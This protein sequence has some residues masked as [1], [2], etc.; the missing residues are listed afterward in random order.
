[1]KTS[2]SPT[3]A[4][5]EAWD[6]LWRRL[7]SPE[8]A[9]RDVLPRRRNHDLRFAHVLQ[10]QRNAEKKTCQKNKKVVSLLRTG[11]AKI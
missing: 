1:M 9:G 11:G 3:A 4:Q 6:E 10:P 5:L 8:D 7:L 2:D